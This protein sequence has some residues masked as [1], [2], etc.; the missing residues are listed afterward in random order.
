MIWN[1]ERRQQFWTD[2]ADG[3][4]KDENFSPTD[5]LRASE[6]LGRSEGDF[7]DRR[8]LGGMGESRPIRLDLSGLPDEL[9]DAVVNAID[10]AEDKK[11]PFD[12]AK[13]KR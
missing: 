5:R 1:R 7:I 13:I 9:I 11:P 6:L 2:V 8:L 12:M 10:K 3:K 4:L